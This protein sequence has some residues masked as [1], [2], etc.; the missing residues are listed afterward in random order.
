MMRGGAVAIRTAGLAAAVLAFL[1][2]CGEETRRAIGIDRRAPD[3]FV[4]YSRAPLSLPPDYAL[5]PPSP[6]VPRPQEKPVSEQARE[7]L[8]GAAIGSS[9]AGTAS[10]G[11]SALLGRAGA[12]GA[13]PS[14]RDAVDRE[15]ALLA[16]SERSFVN[17]LIFWRGPKP[18]GEALDAEAEA[19]RL[20]R[21]P[22]GAPR[23]TDPPPVIER[24]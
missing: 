24:R 22:R 4:V 11:E 19:R 3:E 17:K 23:D 21:E 16:E 5:R 7:T 10:P 1:A 12:A 2:G 9:A 15:T 13:D 6:G 8:L 18:V 20:G 14:I